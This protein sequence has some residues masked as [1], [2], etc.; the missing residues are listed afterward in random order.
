MYQNKF[1]C[2]TTPYA[3]H[4]ICKLYQNNIR[5]LCQKKNFC[6]VTWNVVIDEE[7]EDDI[8]R[9]NTRSVIE[10]TKASFEQGFRIIIHNS[11]IIDDEVSDDDDEVK[12]GKAWVWRHSLCKL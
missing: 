5:K 6:N 10:V 1:F 3:N 11:E 7:K 2:I 12:K 8:L 4:N 9:I